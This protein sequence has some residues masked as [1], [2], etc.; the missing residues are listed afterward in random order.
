MANSAHA[1]GAGIAA[2]LAAALPPYDP[3]QPQRD[4]RTRW[5][6][7]ASLAFHVLLLLLFW[8]TL[9]G[10]V[11]EEEETVTV[12]MVE[13]KPKLER[14]VLAQRRI[15][16]QVRRFKDI[17]Q[18]EI[19]RVDPVP[20]LDQA[21]KVE[22]DPTR[23]TVA[24]KEISTRKVVTKTVSAFADV[25][26]QVQP[27]QIDRVAPTVRQVRV[28]Q[29]SAGPRKTEAAGPKVTAQAV[30]VEAPAVT[31]GQISR[32]AVAGDVQGARIAA[33]ESGTS[34]RFLRGE[35]RP[36]PLTDK[37]C[38]K[39]P[40]CVEYLQMIKE[41]VYARWELGADT[42][43]GMVRLRFKIDRGGS[44]HAVSVQHADDGLLGQTC[45]VAFRHA[46]PFPPPPKAIHYL[47]GKG[48][49]ATFRH[50]DDL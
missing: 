24:P 42:V 3:M 12:R 9:I 16:T 7:L 39:G 32:D 47:V 43:P 26:T 49:I 25:P 33:L 4:S 48:I 40:V 41:R 1:M 27:I 13:E 45:Q 30:D 29:A 28:A 19:V 31:Q 36:G 20:V 44:A 18:P 8:D 11:L 2:E 14:K 17:A 50:G 22:V 21:K 34:D 38:E 37:D 35:G 10:A 5:L 23:I 15:D 6:L 46:S